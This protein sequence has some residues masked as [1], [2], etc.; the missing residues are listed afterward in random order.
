MKLYHNAACGKSRLAIAHLQAK[1]P[2]LEVVNYLETRLNAAELLA[3]IERSDSPPEDFVRWDDARML[4]IK[5][6]LK[7]DAATNAELLAKHP[8]ILQRPLVDN[9]EKVII[10]RSDEVLKQF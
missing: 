6:E 3:L 8:K 5:P 2:D 9:G 4:G 10:C 7:T 1:H